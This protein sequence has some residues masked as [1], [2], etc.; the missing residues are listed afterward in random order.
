VIGNTVTHTGGYFSNR[1]G[2]DNVW[3][4][5]WLDGTD[6]RVYGKGTQIIGNYV[7]DA[8]I[9]LLLG[10]LTQDELEHSYRYGKRPS[11]TEPVAEDTLV[12]GNSGRGRIYIGAKYDAP[13]PVEDTRL[14]ANTLEIIMKK[15][16][17]TYGSA[18][19]S[20]YYGTAR[21]LTTTDVG[22]NAPDLSCQADQKARVDRQPELQMAGAAK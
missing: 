6:L 7:V 17:G 10:T 20:I 1:H 3:K 13:I 4:N 21:K 2:H 14:E 18:E 5:N 15:G 9:H 12:V 8:N 16:T 22:L 19:T 11:T